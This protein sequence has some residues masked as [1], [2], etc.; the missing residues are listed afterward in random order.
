LELYLSSTEDRR[1]GK[2]Y[3][4]DIA[5]HIVKVNVILIQVA[6]SGYFYPLPS[7]STFLHY[8]HLAF[9][10]SDALSRYLI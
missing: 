8:S 7:T 1:Q 5:E 6:K 10:D 4:S 9:S 2:W 3:D